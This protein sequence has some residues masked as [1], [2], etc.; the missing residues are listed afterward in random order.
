MVTAV[1]PA[2]PFS[3]CVTPGISLQQTSGMKTLYICINGLFRPLGIF[4]L[5]AAGLPSCSRLRGTQG[6]RPDPACTFGPWPRS[7]APAG[8]SKS[9]IPTGRHSEHVGPSRPLQTH[10]QVKRMSDGSCDIWDLECNQCCQ[11][12]LGEGKVFPRY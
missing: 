8:G 5:P 7:V 1:L 3:T 6:A 10:V 9:H 4:S 2:C 12:L 11:T